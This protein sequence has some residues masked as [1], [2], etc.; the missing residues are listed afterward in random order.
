[1]LNK[2]QIWEEKY[3]V[4]SASI[5]TADT[6][7][8]VWLSQH[9]GSIC[10]SIYNTMNQHVLCTC[11]VLHYCHIMLCYGWMKDSSKYI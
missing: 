3:T 2:H 8:F 11:V 9:L 1:M 6:L 5:V 4:Y 7:T 10:H